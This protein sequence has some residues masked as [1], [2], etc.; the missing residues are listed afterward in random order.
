MQMM[1]GSIRLWRVNLRR[2][3]ANLVTP[4]EFTIEFTKWFLKMDG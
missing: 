1:P 2:P 4:F 3:A